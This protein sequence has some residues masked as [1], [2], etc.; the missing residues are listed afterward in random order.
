MTDVIYKICDAAFYSGRVDFF[1][2]E[3]KKKIIRVGCLK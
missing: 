3:K 1:F 2:K